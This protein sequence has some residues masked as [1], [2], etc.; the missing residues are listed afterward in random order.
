VID[1]C[2]A[3]LRRSHLVAF[4]AGDIRRLRT[5]EGDEEAQAFLRRFDARRRRTAITALGIDAACP[6]SGSFPKP[7]R[8]LRDPPSV[9][10][11]TALARVVDE[12]E[13]AAVVIGSRRPS[14]YGRT[15]AYGL[16]R[17]LGAAGVPVISGLALG[18]D[19]VA[20]GGCLD[21]GG[22][23]VAVLA[24]GVDVPYPRT[25]RRLY[26]RV[27]DLGTIVSEMP[28]GSRPYRWLFPARNRIMAAL[29]R[30]TVVV[31]AAERSGTLITADCAAEL[32][33]D[34]AA[35]PGP[36]TSSVAA[37]TNGLLRNGAALVTEAQDVL[38]LLY[39]V[40]AREVPVEPGPVLDPVDARVL[41]AV[42][43]GG[44]LD[45]IAADLSLTA[46]AVRAALARLELRGLVRR[47]A[48]GGYVPR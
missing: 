29:G 45:Q 17:G 28:P 31:E 27:R 18:I 33:R 30:L 10:Y 13:P 12:R 15:V 40:G 39:G 46:A 25:N 47:A 36:V 1:A 14:E 20:H 7:L 16:G 24:C 38:D 42:S 43:R 23:T 37:G 5:Y 48:A 6:H 11:A 34:V 3:C 41:E 26:R 4:L 22:R 21:G 19:A 44:G 9:L 35:V 2:D 32:G 8:E